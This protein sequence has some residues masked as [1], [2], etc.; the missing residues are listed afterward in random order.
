MTFSIV[1]W[2]PTT[3]MTGVAVATKHLAVGALVP[4]TQANVGEIATQAQTNPQIANKFIFSCPPY[5]YW[6]LFIVNC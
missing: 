3:K 2:N 5:Y 6:R 1:A 4:H